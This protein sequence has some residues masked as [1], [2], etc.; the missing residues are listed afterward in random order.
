MY[1]IILSDCSRF[2]ESSFER[3][4]LPSDLQEGLSVSKPSNVMLY[5]IQR[6]KPS[7]GRKFLVSGLNISWESPF[8]GLTF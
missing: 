3:S 8:S 5:P 4:L 2:K 6:E 7:A 1:F